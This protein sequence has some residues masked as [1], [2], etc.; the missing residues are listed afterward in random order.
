[1]GCTQSSGRIREI[2][3]V[4][5]GLDLSGKT[6]LL[7]R[8]KHDTIVETI[9][10]IGFNLEFLQV[11]GIRVCL[12]DIGGQQILRRLWR[13]YYDENRPGIVIVVDSTD[14]RPNRLCCPDSQCGSCLNEELHTLFTRYRSCDGPVLIFANKQDMIGAAM[15]PE[16]LSRRLNLHAWRDR[17]YKILVQPCCAL[18]GQGL[19][20]GLSWLLSMAQA[21]RNKRPTG[22]SVC[23][24]LVERQRIQMQMY[25]NL[26]L[27]ELP[28]CQPP[29]GSV[30]GSVRPV[31][32]M[33]APPIRF[34]FMDGASPD[35]ARLADLRS[36]CPC[37]FCRL[38]MEIQ[39]ELCACLT[40]AD[41]ARVGLV[42]ACWAARALAFGP[43]RGYLSA[44]S[45]HRQWA[46]IML[47]RPTRLFFGPHCA[48]GLTSDGQA[49]ASPRSPFG[50]FERP[51]RLASPAATGATDAFFID[52]AC[53]ASHV[54]LLSSSG[55]LYRLAGNVF[56]A[57][58]TP[59]EG[60]PAGLVQVRMGACHTVA[61][62]SLGEMHT[63][64][65]NHHGQ[66]GTGMGVGEA[67]DAL[68]AVP[69]PAGLHTRESVV[70]VCTGA[71]H[72]VART[73]RGR[74]LAWGSNGAGQCGNGDRVDQVRPVWVSL[75]G[76]V[77]HIACGFAHTL[78]LTDSGAIYAWGSNAHGQLGDGTRTDRAH[79]VCVQLP[80]G[81][82]ATRV[83]CGESH[84]LA[85]TDRGALYAWGRSDNWQFGPPGT[86]SELPRLLRPVPV[87]LPGVRRGQEL[88]WA[89]SSDESYVWDW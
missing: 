29:P 31:E 50:L 20:A 61:L 73:S 37:A 38:P 79:P 32:P 54:L 7:Y 66:L 87:E 1:M 88:H 71:F 24:M 81:E 14:Y 39:S 45:P 60:C 84:C 67:S 33:K 82:R 55:Q 64:G 85:L 80:P 62:S 34:T 51:M 27:E 18:T 77:T 23:E 36:V 58:L 41:F 59:L 5:I 35:A 78:A 11:D 13:H 3:F 22:P 16:E 74:L 8:L 9:P 21:R 69:L 40:D 89:V 65:E 46:S 75:P 44:R 12:W 72:T 68:C 56:D 6:K 10:T 2:S 28:P 42:S 63:M 30:D 19:M 43:R 53:G 52:A 48:L 57:A 70:Q 4:L 76:H 86:L 17:G 49:F 25:A 47:A 83:I 15:T 26:Q